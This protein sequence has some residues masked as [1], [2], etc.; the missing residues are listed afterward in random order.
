MS[1]YGGCVGGFPLFL[2]NFV[3]NFPTSGCGGNISHCIPWIFWVGF[4]GG[5]QESGVP[6]C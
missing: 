6:M 5:I 4:L 3:V 1:S 2:W